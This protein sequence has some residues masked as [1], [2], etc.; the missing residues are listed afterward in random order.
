MKEKLKQVSN[1]KWRL[2]KG[3]RPGMRVPAVIYATKR[4]IDAA[5]DTAIEQLTNVACLPGVI[6]PVM[7][8]PDIHW[9]YGLPMGAVGAFDKDKGIISCGCTGFDINCG[10]HMIRT[11]LE[12]KEVLAKL[13]PLI[14]TLFANVPC[15]V[16]AKGKLRISEAELDRVLVGG[17]R[18]AL[19]NGYA[20]KKDVEHMEEEGCIAGADPTK[21]S[22]LAKRRG[23]PQLGT[24]GA[25]NH[26]LEVQAVDQ[27][28]D[29]KT[30]KAFGITGKDQV[31]VMLHCGSRGFGHQVAT[32]YLKIHAG[33]AKKYGIKLPDPQLVCAP[34]TSKEG[35]DYF[36]AMKCA[37]NYA[38][39]NRTVMTKWIRDCFEKV[40][41]R[42]WEDMDM[43]L[44]YDVC[45]N[46]CK[47]EE[48]EVAG[49]KTQL[50]VHRK[51]AT[52]SLPPGHKLVPRAYRAVGQPVLI[53][54]T[55]GTASYILVGGEKAKETFYSSCHGAGRVMSRHAA[56]RKY[57]G[58]EV[59]KA[60]ETRG[61][62][63]RSTHPKVL[64][65]EAPGAYKDVDEVVK[66]VHQAGI[67]LKVA[68][69]VPLGVAKG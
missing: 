44:I 31:L 32:D 18:W 48:H 33:A 42:D 38:F 54:G 56:I 11:N 26:Y 63:V 39:C 3:A 47:L 4:I 16:G 46:I 65:E 21:V 6:A 10:I 1:V 69:M 36:K 24:L 20:V 68:R 2:E 15:G 34:T 41:G 35:Q 25:G 5:E 55:M 8:M 59:K 29:Q 40:L 43:H 57:W 7:G 45:H 52:R 58:T 17:A 22:E 50:Y 12:K 49:K 9:G 53:G 62:V 60:L 14:D 23:R 66:A 30:A 27:I 61:E 19:E 13:K 64:A 67:S 28:F 37:V 51:G